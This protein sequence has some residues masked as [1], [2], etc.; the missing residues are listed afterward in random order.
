MLSNRIKTLPFEPMGLVEGI[1]KNLMHAILNGVLKGGE[2]LIEA[3]LQEI[4]GVSK[5]PVREALRDLANK[6]LV[7]IK[8]RKGAF[9]KPITRTDIVENYKV[10]A[11]LEGLAVR[12]AYEKMSEADLERMKA[13]LNRM[14]S[15]ARKKKYREYFD[16]DHE[17]HNIY[18]EVCGN[19]LLVDLLKGLRMHNLWYNFDHEYYKKDFDLREDVKPHV[20]L[21]EALQNKKV[22]SKK[23]EGMMR[24][25]IEKA[26]NNFLAYVNEGK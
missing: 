25:A 24:E 22:G 6:G 8:P 20:E 4:F 13:T 5:S 19:R 3:E 9:V 23:I 14:V 12:E 18:L 21:V 11:V 7:E 26:L 15:A 1:S 10:R 17:L 16:H 2:Q